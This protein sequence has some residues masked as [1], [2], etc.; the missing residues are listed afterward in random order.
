[1]TAIYSKLA[2]QSE[3][4]ACKAIHD[5]IE[6]NMNSIQNFNTN[7]VR[8]KATSIPPLFTPTGNLANILPSF[9]LFYKLKLYSRV[10]KIQNKFLVTLFKYSPRTS[11]IVAQPFEAFETIWK[12]EW[13]ETSPIDPP[14]P[15]LFQINNNFVNLIPQ[16]YRLF[17]GRAD[18]DRAAAAPAPTQNE[19]CDSVYREYGKHRL[20][21]HHF[22][23]K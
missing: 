17:W 12:S 2:L 14:L 20:W 11:N 18:H 7:K 21:D 9:R 4:E 23:R 15:N 10:F 19:V 16:F 1:M 6:Q 3:Y 13:I 5:F 22:S 8:L